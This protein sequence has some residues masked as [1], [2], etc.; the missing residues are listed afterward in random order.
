MS[1]ENL[2]VLEAKINGLITRHE[3]MRNERS[4]LLLR[5]DEK[6]REQSTLLERLRQYEQERNE[7]RTIL[8]KIMSRFDGLD[9]Q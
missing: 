9:I 2:K 4:E 6:E 1:V 5:I 8:E 7:M 3:Q